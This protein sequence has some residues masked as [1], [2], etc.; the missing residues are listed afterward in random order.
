MG[1]AHG[2]VAYP[3][4]TQRALDAM[5]RHH[6]VLDRHP[7][8]ADREAPRDH[9]QQLRELTPRDVLGLRA[10]T[11]EVDLVG[12]LLRAQQ[13]GWAAHSSSTTR[14]VAPLGIMKLTLV[15]TRSRPNRNSSTG[16]LFGRRCAISACVP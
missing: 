5:T 2:D 10:L 8:A 4:H 7:A 3:T 12:G 11:G 16:V 9:A 1:G 6:G 15:L 13:I 14:T